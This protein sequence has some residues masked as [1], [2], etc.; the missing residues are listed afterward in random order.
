MACL[1]YSCVEKE[2]NQKT[3]VSEEIKTCSLIRDFRKIDKS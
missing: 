3:N 2:G 1:K